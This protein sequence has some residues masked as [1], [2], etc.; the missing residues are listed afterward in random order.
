MKMT[1][2]WSLFTSIYFNTT[3]NLIFD[4]LLNK[5]KKQQNYLV[6]LMPGPGFPTS[7]IVQ[8]FY[9]FNELRGGCLFCCWWNCWPSLFKLF[10][11][12]DYFFP[13]FIQHIQIIG[14]R[15]YWSCCIV[16]LSQARSWISN[17]IY[18]GLFISSMS[19]VRWEVIVH[20]V[21]VDH[22]F[23]LFFHSDFFPYFFSTYKLFYW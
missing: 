21:V 6:F 2:T 19:W 17:V 20:F 1:R 15:F 9:M 22:L 23:K 12:N 4:R 3:K 13:Y 16:C 14:Q 7:Y 10:F 18:R 11:H 8:S 5:K